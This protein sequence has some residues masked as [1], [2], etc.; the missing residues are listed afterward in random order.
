MHSVNDAQF[1]KII[2]LFLSP[3]LFASSSPSPII[4]IVPLTSMHHYNHI[5]LALSLAL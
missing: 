3:A 5:N 1:L 2:P 4:D